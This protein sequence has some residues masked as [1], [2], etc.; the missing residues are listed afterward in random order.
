MDLIK[1]SPIKEWFIYLLKPKS[2]LLTMIMV[3]FYTIYNKLVLPP[4]H[5]RHIPYVNFFALLRNLWKGYSYSI[6]S[7]NLFIPLLNEK[8]QIYMK[9]D[10]MGWVVEV[11]R[12]E[13]TKQL[14]LKTDVFPKANVDGLMGS[15]RQD[16]VGGMN[17]IVFASDK[18][19]HKKHRMILSPAFHR[20]TPV[21]LFTNLS[22]KLFTIIDESIDQQ[23]NVSNLMERFTLDVIGFDFDFNAIANENSEWVNVYNTIKTAVQSPLFALFPFLD[24]YFLWLLP[25][26]KEKHF[27]AQR[28]QNMLQ[29][30]IEHKRHI[31]NKQK[32]YSMDNDNDGEKDLLTLMLESE[33]AGEGSLN[34]DEIRS[35]LNIFFLERYFFV[36]IL[37]FVISFIFIVIMIFTKC[38]WQH[39]LANL[40]YISHDTTASSLSSVIYQLAK[41]LDVQQRAREEV[42]KV[43]GDDPKEIV[44]TLNQLKELVYLNQIIKETLRLSGPAIAITPRV[45]SQDTELS[46]VYIPKGTNI[47]VNIFDLHHNPYVW[48]NP[49]VFN[50]D[51]FIKGGEADKLARKGYSWTSFGGGSRM[52]MGMNFSLIE[53]RV[54]LSCLLKKYEFYLPK[55]SIHKDTLMT[56]TI[57]VIAPKNLNILFKSRY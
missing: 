34:N 8:N 28:F 38:S 54:F 6:L 17:N 9:R 1:R 55:D 27:L 12:P 29:D 31:L 51:R 25:K 11:C 49:Q 33:L 3:G 18:K 19:I 4:V 37:I 2:M 21:I 46:G 50:P 39:I 24:Q 16:F 10:A 5:L 41:N 20:S 45:T 35:D 15:L 30:I 14:L 40:F 57:G 7:R 26:R 53:Q 52:C 43:F 47:V 48:K 56:N 36:L 23:I 32:K 22:Y 13:D 44:P 42:I